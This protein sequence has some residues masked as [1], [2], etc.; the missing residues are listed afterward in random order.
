MLWASALLVFGA[1]ALVVAGLA[2]GD[3]LLPGLPRVLQARTPW[4]LLGMLWGGC[5]LGAAAVVRRR[6]WGRYAVLGLEVASSGLLSWYFLA[7]SMLPPHE[8]AV[9]VGEP[10]PGYALADQD[11]RL[12]RV[13]ARAPREPVLFVFYRGDW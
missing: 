12:H 13:E 7:S 1:V 10:F 9:R 5:A 4:L 8:L 3:E 2:A 11:G 6:A